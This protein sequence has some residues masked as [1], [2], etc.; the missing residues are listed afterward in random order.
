[1]RES[2]RF[3]S[4]ACLDHVEALVAHVV[5][6]QCASA[7]LIVCDQHNSSFRISHY[8]RSNLRRISDQQQY[9]GQALVRFFS[10]GP[11]RA[12]QEH[13]TPTAFRARGARCGPTGGELNTRCQ[14]GGVWRHGG[15][16][17][18][19]CPRGKF[20]PLSYG[21]TEPAEPRTGVSATAVDRRN[22]SYFPAV[23]LLRRTTDPCCAEQRSVSVCATMRDTLADAESRRNFPALQTSGRCEG[24][25][26]LTPEPH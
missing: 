3:V 22:T 21:R 25:P 20:V 17:T 18:L 19:L 9:S 14:A 8:S 6:N 2:P 12:I 15:A 11:F 26:C 24:H 23:T 5:G 13:P 1:M 4:V 16:G 10:H 7:R